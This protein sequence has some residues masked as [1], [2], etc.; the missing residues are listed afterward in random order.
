[1]IESRLGVRRCGSCCAVGPASLY[2]RLRAA[3]F[4]PLDFGLKFY[5]LL[6]QALN[7]RNTCKQRLPQFVV[8]WTV[9]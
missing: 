8:T 9:Y 3:S 1:M 4:Q 6:V 7:F 5:S 2:T